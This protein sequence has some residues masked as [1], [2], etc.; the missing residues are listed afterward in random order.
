MSDHMHWCGAFYPRGNGETE[1]VISF[2][3]TDTVVS[4]QVEPA[5]WKAMKEAGDAA[6]RDAQAR[7]G[8]VRES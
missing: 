7:Q 2:A 1:L 5:A 4:L 8:P 6:F 3:E